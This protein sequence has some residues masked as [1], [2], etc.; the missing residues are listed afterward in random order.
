MSF[1]LC[2]L[3]FLSS[4]SYSLYFEKYKLFISLD[5]FIRRFCILF[6][7]VV[8]GIVFLISLSDSFLLPYRS[9]TGFCPVRPPYLWFLHLRIQPNTVGEEFTICGWLDPWVWN[10][11]MHMT[12]CKELEHLKILVSK[13]GSWSQSPVDTK[14]QHILILNPATVWKKCI[15]IVF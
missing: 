6:D 11:Q 3:Q 5:M 12:N 14:E 4:V 7:V 15:W 2:C 10:L 13:R 9:A 8:N 1:H